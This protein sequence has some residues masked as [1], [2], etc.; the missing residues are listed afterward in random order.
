MYSRDTG[1]GNSRGGRGVP[2]LGCL[3]G[4]EQRDPWPARCVRVPFEPFEARRPE[5]PKFGTYLVAALAAARLVPEAV[6]L[7][8]RL[9]G[10][11]GEL[12]L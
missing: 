6:A 11:P 12:L 1:R 9:L 4:S 8:R 5:D 3:R 10:V 2:R 7:H